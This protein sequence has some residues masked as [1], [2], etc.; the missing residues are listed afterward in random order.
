MAN[1]FY[2]GHTPKIFRSYLGLISFAVT[3]SHLSSPL[4]MIVI[5][6]QKSLISPADPSYKN[7]TKPHGKRINNRT[8]MKQQQHNQTTTKA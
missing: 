2:L 4:L 7:Q 1:K 5:F 8:A 3:L 6:C